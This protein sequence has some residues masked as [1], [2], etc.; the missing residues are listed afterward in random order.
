MTQCRVNQIVNTYYD[1]L[2]QNG[3]PEKYVKNFECKD[4]EVIVTILTGNTY[5]KQFK[6]S[7]VETTR[8]V[9]TGMVQDA[10]IALRESGI[11]R[12][13]SEATQHD[14]GESRNNS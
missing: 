14:Q 13:W 3:I 9:R 7:Y 2:M 8:N 10:G 4:N 5:S 6:P 11:Q 1:I 12:N